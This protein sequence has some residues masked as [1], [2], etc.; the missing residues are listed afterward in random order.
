MPQRRIFPNAKLPHSFSSKTNAESCPNS[1]LAGTESRERDLLRV[2]R[3]RMHESSPILESHTIDKPLS[4]A[5]ANLPKA[6]SAPNTPEYYFQMRS[7]PQSSSERMKN[8]CQPPDTMLQQYTLMTYSSGPM[9]SSLYP[10][11]NVSLPYAPPRCSS[12]SHHND[13]NCSTA[14]S[15]MKEKNPP[16]GIYQGQ[17]FPAFFNP[18]TASNMPHKEK[19]NNWIENIPIY[20]IEGGIWESKCY[21]NNYSMNWE[22]NEFDNPTKTNSISYV[23]HDELLYLQ[24]RKFESLVRKLYKSEDELQVLHKDTLVNTNALAEYI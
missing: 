4:S 13:V 17:T 6:P 21:D 9:I 10:K 5:I 22:E 15:H 3:N 24:A 11:Y 20:E 19:V 8:Y 7:T 16:P 1:F 2:K 12:Y 14:Q 23:T 18:R